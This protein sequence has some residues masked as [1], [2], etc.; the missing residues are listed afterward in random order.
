MS[1]YTHNDDVADLLYEAEA[2]RDTYKAKIIWLQT[3][4]LL[5]QRQIA[6]LQAEV[7]RLETEYS[8]GL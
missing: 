4:I 7:K 1:E 3:D 2:Q 6:E 5:L 8:R